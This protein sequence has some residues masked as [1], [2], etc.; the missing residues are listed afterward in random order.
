MAIQL[1]NIRSMICQIN[2]I[3]ITNQNVMFIDILS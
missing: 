2:K 1:Y 3:L